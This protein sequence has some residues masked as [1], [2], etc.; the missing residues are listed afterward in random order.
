MS[1][2]LKCFTFLCGIICV[3]LLFSPSYDELTPITIGN[4]PRKKFIV[5]TGL[6][7][8]LN[9]QPNKVYQEIASWSLQAVNKTVTLPKLSSL[10]DKGWLKYF[11]NELFSWS[12]YPID[13]VHDDLEKLNSISHEQHNSSFGNLGKAVIV[14][15]KLA[16]QS[17]EKMSLHQLNVVASDI[18]SLN[19]RLE[20]MRPSR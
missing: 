8:K 19:R 16:K 3:L 13:F 18:M 6:K 15:E 5:N 4:V 11:K 9:M 12:E 20:D 2:T 1:T 14:P 17:K 10:N 7:D